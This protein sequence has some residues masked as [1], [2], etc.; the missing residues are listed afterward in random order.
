[1]KRYHW[2]AGPVLM[3]ALGALATGAGAGVWTTMCP[4]WSP[5]APP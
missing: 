4:S 5:R 3:L 1:M 2:L